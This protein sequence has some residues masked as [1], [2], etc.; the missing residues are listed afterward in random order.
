MPV[1]VDETFDYALLEGASARAGRSRARAPRRTTRRGR[2]GRDQAGLR[3]ARARGRLRAVLQVLDEEPVLPLALLEA[4]LRVA[5]DVALPAGH[6]ARGGDPARHRGAARNEG[7]AAAR[8]HARARTRGAARD[9]R[10]GAVGARPAC[11]L[12]ERDPLA[13]SRGRG[14]ARAPR[15]ARL[16]LAQA[17]H[18]SA[19]RA[20]AHRARVPRRARRSISRSPNGRSRARRSSSSSCTR[21]ATRP[22]PRAR[23]PSLRALVESGFVICEERE[24]VRGPSVEPLVPSAPAPELTPH[25][26]IALGEI[27]SCDRSAHATRSSCSTASPAAARRRS[28]SARPTWRSRSGRS[29]IVLVPE[30]SLTHQVVDRFRARFG[31]RVAVLHSGL[32]AGERF[33]Q[34]RLIREGRVPIA[35]GARSAVFAP[36]HRSGSDRDRRGARR[37]RTRA[38]RASAT[39]RATSR[40]CAPSARAA[41]SCSAPRRPTSGRR[42]ARAHGRARAPAPCPSASRAGRCRRWRSSTWRPERARGATARHALAPAAPGARRDARGRPAGDPVPEP[43]RLRGATSTASRCGHAL[44]CNHCDISL[45]YHASEGLRRVDDPLEGELRCHYCGYRED[46]KSRCP[47]CGSPEGGMQAFGTERLRRGGHRDV[48]RARASAASTAT[49]PRARARSAASSRRSTAASST[50]WSA[51]RWSPRATTSRT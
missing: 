24:L 46:P 33:D 16:R 19:A 45:V 20:S 22:R 26:K 8:R 48:S 50:C 3:R 25:Q 39:T 31:D 42:R 36:L 23:P 12:R 29:A 13:L 27:A 47:S 14:R 28:T 38:T 49:R 4:V 18:R 37:R 21:S 5:R 34:W 40:G 9:A 2:G 17:R 30:I 43:A 35:I 10:Q 6:R 1:P 41:R 11:A 51:R 32:S 15:A 44:R 7:D